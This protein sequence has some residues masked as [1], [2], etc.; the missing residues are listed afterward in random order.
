MKT[1]QDIPN[2]YKA[3]GTIV[4]ATV[5]MLTYHDQFITDAE[6]ME[7][8]KKNDAQIQFL[9]V[10]GYEREKTILIKEKVLY[11]ER[12][13]KPEVARVNEEIQTLRDKI[14]GICDQIK[15]C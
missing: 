13:N 6:A 15:D 11:L 9:L 12:D 8:Q 7:Q 5:F 14:K 2:A 1:W 3:V 10:L 4:V